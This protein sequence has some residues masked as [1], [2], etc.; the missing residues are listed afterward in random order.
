[1]IARHSL[2]SS[3]AATLNAIDIIKFVS[4]EAQDFMDPVVVF[5]M[6]AGA[7]LIKPIGYVK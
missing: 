2:V 1:M 4:P 3:E 6:I 7:M 5:T